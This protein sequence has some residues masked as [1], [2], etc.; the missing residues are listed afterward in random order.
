VENR[1]EQLPVGYIAI[2][3]LHSPIRKVNYAV[4]NAR[5]GQR[6]DYDA[7]T[8]EVWTDGS[9]KP[10]ESISLSSKILKEQVADFLNF[11]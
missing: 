6:T 11:R 4:S 1:T 8:L 5:V 7:L 3:A 2:D 10:E 9:L